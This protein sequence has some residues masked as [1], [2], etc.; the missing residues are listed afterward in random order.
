MI[1]TFKLVYYGFVPTPAIRNPGFAPDLLAYSSP[2]FVLGPMARV[3]K[4]VA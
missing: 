3:K 4:A 1:A 2:S